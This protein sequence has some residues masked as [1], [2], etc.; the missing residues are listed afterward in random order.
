MSPAVAK[1]REIQVAYTPWWNEDRGVGQALLHTSDAKFRLLMAGR[2]SGKTTCAVAEICMDA[3]AHPGHTNWWVTESLEIKAPAWNAL[4]DFLPKEVISKTNQ[5]ERLIRLTNG[6]EIYVKSAKGDK[7]LISASLDFVVCDEAGLWKEEAWERGIS[8]MLV[9]RPHARVL[10]VSTPRSRNWFWRM[11]NKGRP[12]PGKE[13]E[14]ESFHWKSEDS[15]YADL[16]YLA[17]R[18]KNMPAD[19]YAEEFEAD[20]ID[21]AGG[22]FRNVRNCIG[23]RAAAPDAL[24]CIGVDLGQK[25]DFTAMI[26]MNS[27][28]QALFVERM[29]DDYPIQKQRLGAMVFQMNFGRLVVDE[30]N[31]GLAIV[32]DLRSAGFPVESVATNSAPVKRAL[33]ENLRVAFQQNTL[34]IPDD[35]VLL[36]ELEAYSYEVL[37]SGQIRYSAPDGQHDDTVIALALAL[38][39]QR[40]SLY[41]YAQPARAT[42]YAGRG[43]PSY[44]R[45]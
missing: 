5:V 28:R 12:G 22:V 44:G 24:T 41:Q 32:Q 6:S 7:S 18:R 40:G 33:I 21:S 34:S 13:P 8:P 19:L 9:A 10:L 37:P 16:G 38:W 30:A 45:R 3:L 17:E 11:W 2:Q 4:L 35:P 1:P 43:G 31:I 15:P 20:P 23:Y 26:P 14:Y 42:S 39:G 25:H 27:K 29:Q 36:D